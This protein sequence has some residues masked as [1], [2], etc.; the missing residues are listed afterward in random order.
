[1]TTTD[2]TSYD[3]D[4]IQVLE[5]LEAVRKRPGM[6]I[7]NTDVMGLHHCVFEVVDNS[8]TYETPILMA[9]DGELRLRPI[10]ELIDSYMNEFS[11][12]VEGGATMQ[13]LRR[14]FNLQALTFS[15]KDYRLSYQPISS[16]IRH[17][18]NSSIYRIHLATGRQVEITPY[19]SLFTLRKGEVVSVRGDELNPGDYVI[20][21]RTW[22]EPP[23]YVTEINLVNQ[24]LALPP[25]RTEKFYLYGVR[26]ALTAGVREALSGSLK[27][28]ESWYDYNHYDYL[29]FNLLRQLPPTII[30]HLPISTR[31][32][33]K[34][35]KFPIRL[36]VS[37]A[38]IELLGIYAAEGCV[39]HDKAK[40]H[41][42][43]VF[44]FGSH[45]SDQIDYTLR[46]IKEVFDLELQSHYVHESARIIKIGQELVAVLFADILGTGEESHSKQVPN[47]IFNL[48]P[49][50]RERYLIAY[51][52]G[53]G[54]PSTIFANHLHQGSTPNKEDRHK[55]TFVTAS[56][57]L[58]SALHY[59]LAS[60]GKTWSLHTVAAAEV[61]AERPILVNYRGKARSYTLCERSSSYRTAFYWHSNAS[62]IHNLPFDEVVA[63]CTDRLTRMAHRRGQIGI[64]RPKIDRLRGDGKLALYEN[65]EAFLEGDLGLLKVT[66]IE[67][68][69]DYAHPWVYDVSVP[70]GENFVAGWGPVM[71]HNS[72]DEALQGHGNR[73][74]VVI[75]S[76]Q[77]M[78]VRDY[79]RGVPVDIHKETGLPA[80]EVIMTRLHAGG[81]F[82]GSGYKVSGGLHG[83]GVKAVN[84]VSEWMEVKV[85]RNGKLYRQRYERGIAVTPV[86]VIGKVPAG[87]TGTETSWSFDREIFHAEGLAYNFKTLA[88]RFRDM[89]FLTPSLQISLVDEREAGQEAT[90]YFQGGI[91]SFVAYLNRTRQR[92]H[93]VIYVNREVDEVLVEVAMQYTD[94]YQES[95]HTFTNNINQPEG[96]MHLTG[97]RGA[98][99]RSIND[100]ARKVGLLKEKDTNFSGEDVREG[101]TA[102][103][104][105]K[106][107]DPQF[108]G[109]TK[110]KLNNTEVKGAVESTVNEALA[111]WF[112]ENPRD[113]KEIINKVLTAS[114]ARAA[115]KKARDM[116]IRKSA[117][118][119]MTL[120]GKLADCSERDPNKSELM[121]V[122]GDSAGG[123]FSGDT[124]V[125][126][127]DGR[128]LSFK[129]LVEEQA[130]GKEHFCY[131]IR[132]DSRIGLERLINVRITKRDAEVIR[133]TLD[134]GETIIC[135]PDHRFMLRDGSYK[136]AASLISDDSLMPLYRKLSSTADKGITINGYEMVWDPS[137]QN[138]LLTDT[139]TEAPRIDESLAREA[140]ANYN[141]RVVSIER[142][143]E[144]LDVYDL[145]V[146]HTHNFALAGGVFVHNSA[147]MGRDRRFQA[148]LPLRGKI[149]NV[150]KARI[151]KVLDNRE[152]QAL[153]SAIGCGI[154]D[155]FDLKHLRYSRVV[156]MTDADVDGS[157]IRTLLLTFF[158]RYMQPLIEHG[159]VFIAQPPLYLLKVGK[160]EHYVYND[161]EKEAKLRQM[162]GKN[163]GIQRYKGLGEMNPEQLWQT[164]LNPEVRTLL[165]VTIEDA[166]EADK[167]FDMLMGSAVPPRKRFIQTHARQ[168][169]NL[170]V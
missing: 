57:S 122:E 20:V 128:A 141:H 164:T 52:S 61:P 116:V 11:A 32:G 166:V 118:E 33:T 49:E 27:R 125:A 51:L 148:V 167:T 139:L 127:A 156:I 108:E 150:E 26:E 152:V 9:E 45:E 72:V 1:M 78:T 21:P 87:E 159:H 169:R 40:D 101:L 4:S 2:P 155:S 66:R 71:C 12:D 114:R 102:I 28:K 94:G 83:I 151:N 147:K 135:T 44:S 74:D 43:L 15:P 153:I 93:P 30:A 157:H 8:L 69:K 96:G 117:L 48:P 112:E 119:S 170:D 25:E 168:V 105:V 36:P 53:D 123:C 3:A 161:Q 39:T 64:S 130:M 41:C 67:E 22:I 47:L 31:V 38:L 149:L 97:F 65:G 115:M 75:H 137:T 143:D 99:T 109:Q 73:I 14:G 136:E 121:L 35:G 60:L 63:N 80:L 110:I 133:L 106:V 92:V 165:Q 129:D 84:A 103:V 70:D 76:D 13:L 6:Y 46:L 144:R 50:L 120:P 95:I 104:S 86:E 62:Y 24:L 34:Y 111:R 131:T 142:L 98:L 146:P 56:Q 5:G 16:L 88:S 89:C 91:A 55:Y 68:I 113:G 23:Q 132:R 140:V 107:K 19:H 163:V 154:G 82:G 158:F 42:S 59:L 29:P 162:A 7:G 134:N 90:Y 124:L 37:Q 79:A 18:V 54:H 17:E 81:K 10:G 85:R 126:L 145:E 77:S 100:Y 58:A 138:W 160:E